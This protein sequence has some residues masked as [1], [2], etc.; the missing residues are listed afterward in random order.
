MRHAR[1]DSENLSTGRRGPLWG[2]RAWAGAL[3]ALTLLGLLSAAQA[4]E[5]AAPA[6]P[7]PLTPEAARALVA[8]LSD[9]EVRGLLLERLDAVAQAEAAAE[10]AP[11]AGLDDAAAAV[12]AHLVDQVLNIGERF[13]ALGR[14]LAAFGAEGGCCC[15]R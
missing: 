10:A 4:Q 9:Q 14:T 11:E 6:L 12:G 13:A 5:A 15:W 3:A 2:L 1:T 7:D 8:G